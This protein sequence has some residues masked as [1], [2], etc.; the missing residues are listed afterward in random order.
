MITLIGPPGELDPAGYLWSNPDV[1]AA[2]HE[3]SDEDFAIWHFD[4]YGRKEGRLQLNTGQLAEVAAMREAKLVRLRERSSRH[5]RRVETEFAGVAM[6]LLA[7]PDDRLPVPFELI[8]ANGYDDPISSWIDTHPEQLFLDMGAGLSHMYRPNVV[9]TEIAALPSV[10]ILAFGDDLP[11]EDA[12]FDGIVSLS[13]LEHVPDPFAVAVELLRV[14]RPG[15]RIVVDWP[16]LQPVHG[17]PNHYFN[18]T[19]EGARVAFERLGASVETSVPSHLHPV[20]VLHWFLR[21]WSVG[22]PDDRRD[23]F[24]ELSVGQV[25]ATANPWEHFDA[26][27]M[28]LRA[29]SQSILAAGTRLTITK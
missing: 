12:T 7:A 22:L 4:R 2:P 19:A 21:D 5:L 3:G 8:S 18:A 26:P 25:L 20:Y 28:A 17:Y 9:Y 10:D 16:F 27:W 29:E 15:G 14:V 23:E 6:S 13:V 11:F 24:L 1:R